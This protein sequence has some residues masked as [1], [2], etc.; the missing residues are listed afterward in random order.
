MPAKRKALAR[1]DIS[2]NAHVQQS[3]RY[4]EKDMSGAQILYLNEF[5]DFIETKTHTLSTGHDK[6]TLSVQL[7][8]A[9]RIYGV[10]YV[11]ANVRL[12]D[13]RSG[14]LRAGETTFPISTAKGERAYSF[15]LEQMQSTGLVKAF[16]LE[17]S[18]F[19]H[20]LC[21]PGETWR[22]IGERMNNNAN[23]WSESD[24]SLFR[25]ILEIPSLFE[26][27]NDL[28]LIFRANQLAEIRYAEVLNKQKV[29]VNLK[30][31]E[32]ITALQIVR[33][34]G[35]F[36]RTQGRVSVSLDRSPHALESRFNVPIRGSNVIGIVNQVSMFFQGNNR[37]TIG[38]SAANPHLTMRMRMNIDDG[39]NLFFPLQLALGNGR[40]GWTTFVLDANA[41]KLTFHVDSRHGPVFRTDGFRL[42]RVFRDGIVSTVDRNTYNLTITNEGRHLEVAFRES[43]PLR[44][45][46]GAFLQAVFHGWRH[47]EINLGFHHI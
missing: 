19:F 2:H 20:C 10:Q 46:P 34:N 37:I 30:N 28:C 6:L 4:Q 25:G 23:S 14:Q 38:T 21:D 11:N 12:G 41:R 32:A 39:K 7:H 43:V 17:F 1:L 18:W 27:A 15:G 8:S 3:E 47:Q 16:R 26:Q 5:G 13:L 33:K 22:R 31:A 42:N 24:R 36:D 44:N 45:L 29:R 35:S 9:D 40:S